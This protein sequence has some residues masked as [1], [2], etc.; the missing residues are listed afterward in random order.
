MLLK[1]NSARLGTLI[2]RVIMANMAMMQILR[3]NFIQEV[4]TGSIEFKI[5][6]RLLKWM[7]NLQDTEPPA[8]NTIPTRTLALMLECIFLNP[9]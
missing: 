7:I 1:E 6:S 5:N 9:Y 4:D 8:I 3:H 2:S